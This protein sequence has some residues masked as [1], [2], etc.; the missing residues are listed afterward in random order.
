MRGTTLEEKIPRIIVITTAMAIEL[1]GHVGI[2][3]VHLA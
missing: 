2:L 1:D 3:G